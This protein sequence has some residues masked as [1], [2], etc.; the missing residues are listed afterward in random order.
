MRAKRHR[1][2]G[3]VHGPYQERA[4][5]RVVAIT[6]EGA[7]TSSLCETEAEAQ[8]LAVDLRA[9]LDAKD[10]AVVAAID[11]YIAAQQVRPTKPIKPQSAATLGFRL[12]AMFAAGY[13]MMVGDLSPRWCQDAYDDLRAKPRQANDTHRNT[14]A[15][16]KAF[17]AWC[18]DRGYAARNPMAGVTGVGD[19]NVGKAQLTTDESRDLLPLAVKMAKRGDRGALA[20]ATVLLAALRAGECAAIVARDVDDGGRI[21]IVPKAKTAAGV[22]RLE[23][24]QWLGKLLR[25]AADAS[26]RVFPGDRHWVRY[27]VQRLCRLAGVTKVTAHGLRGTHATIATTAGASSAVVAASLG[28]T[29][30]RITQRHYTKADATDAARS[31]RAQAALRGK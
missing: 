18:M 2:R 25:G 15:A 11:E 19:R 13:D 27:H 23:I 6:H 4:G 20:T 5:W 7:R 26:G 30:V 24:P 31:R 3:R 12:R 17:L 16:S 28:H 14:L 8:R 22:R 29:N 10:I 21:L 9:E 1:G